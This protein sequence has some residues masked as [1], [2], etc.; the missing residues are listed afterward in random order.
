MESC[1]HQLHS[2]HPGLLLLFKTFFN[3][4]VMAIKLN[5]IP[6]I[7]HDSA[8]SARVIQYVLFL[9]SVD[10]HNKPRPRNGALPEPN[11]YKCLVRASLG[12]RKIST[13]V[14]FVNTWTY[15]CVCACVCVW[16]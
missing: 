11:E 7:L 14:R 1:K 16:V 9:F 10:G 3:C 12:N 13:V 6:V 15:L 5:I 2:K 8:V 4:N